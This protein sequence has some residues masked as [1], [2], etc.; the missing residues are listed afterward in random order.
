M[1][2]TDKELN[3]AQEKTSIVLVL[4]PFSHQ[5]G[6]KYNNIERFLRIGM[7]TYEKFLDV[8]CIEDFF[9][10]VPSED[11]ERVKKLL[12]GRYPTY[13]WNV[14]NE[15]SL[16]H[17][18]LPTGWARQQTVKLTISVLVRTKTYLIIDDDTYLTKP[19]TAQNLYDPTNG[20]LIMN[21]TK[22]DFPFFFLWSAQVLKHDFDEV[23]D[24]P[25][26]MA[27]TPEVFRCDVVRD[28]VKWLVEQY[29]THKQWQMYLYQNKYTEYCL[30]W[31][32]LIKHKRAYELYSVDSP[33]A[34][35]GM[36]T[37]GSEHDLRQ[38]VALS[39]KN[40]SN[41]WFSFVQSSLPHSVDDIYQQVKKALG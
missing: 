6:E 25:A 22:I 34:L 10:V 28:L 29:G 21:K 26:H 37:T 33:I 35:Y 3:A 19:F 24:F 4:K 41:Y 12:V 8:S 23:Q 2:N 30:Y 13:P 15:M 11:V 18:S 20:K 27:I 16:L 1:Q 14:L 32:W 7:M 17:P 39:V 9:V 31:I 38:Q 5:Q 36:A 40:N